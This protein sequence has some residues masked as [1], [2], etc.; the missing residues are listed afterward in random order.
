MIKNFAAFILSHG[1][2]N[3]VITYDTLIKTGYTG[4]IYIIIDNEDKTAKEYYDKFGDKVVMFDKK[5]IAKTF[6]EADNFND[7]RA[8]VYARNAC[9]DIAKDLGIKYFIQLDDDYTT[10]RF[11]ANDKG[12]YITSNT[13]ITKLDKIFEAMLN[14]Y[15]S[16]NIH[17]IAMAQGGD[18]IGG[19]NSRVFK[20]KLARKCMNSFICS[21]DRPFQFVGR[22]NEDVNNYTHKGSLGYLFFTIATVR[23]EQ[24][25]TQSNEGGMTDIYLDNG[26]YIKSFYSIIFQPSAVTISLMGNKNNRLHHRVN[27]NATTPVILD[28]KYKKI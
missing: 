19:E 1:R 25:Q 13:A 21:T 2:A 15:K 20:E 8:I 23:L 10:F 24:K 6:D 11:A 7:R 22:I 26:T 17:S 5:K 27:W 12:E 4:D 28:E 16:T 18:F 9:F 3:N 14:F